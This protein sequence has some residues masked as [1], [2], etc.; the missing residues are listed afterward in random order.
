MT[1]LQS[2]IPQ[3]IQLVLQWDLPD[4]A[5]GD[6]VQT[7]ASAL[8]HLNSDQVGATDTQD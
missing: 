4:Q 1:D 2:N 5:L 7:Q 8:A 3:A 6:A